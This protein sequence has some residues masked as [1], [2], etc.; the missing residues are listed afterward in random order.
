MKADKKATEKAEKVATAPPATSQG[1]KAKE[2]EMDPSVSC[3]LCY[4]YRHFA[5]LLS[6]EY[7]RMRIAQIEDTRAQGINPFPHK[8]HVDISLVDYVAK[9]TYLKVDDLLE[10]VTVSVAGMVHFY[11]TYLCLRFR[12]LN[13]QTCGK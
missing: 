2:D 7:R 10:N 13:G 5:F 1:A 12:A 4:S 11:T 8:Y 9:Y 3:L 6:Q